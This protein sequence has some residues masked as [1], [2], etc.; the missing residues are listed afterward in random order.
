MAYNITENGTTTVPILAGSTFTYAVANTFGGGTLSL[1]YKMNGTLYTIA[2]ATLTAATD[3][4]LTIDHP[5]DTDSLFL[6]LAG[7]TSPDIDVHISRLS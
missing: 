5:G 4:P 6:V 3:T 2:D 7:A 1:K